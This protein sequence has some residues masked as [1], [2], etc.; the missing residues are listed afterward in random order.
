MDTLID[1]DTIEHLD[2]DEGITCDYVTE[3]LCEEAAVWSILVRCC[4]TKFFFCQT[5]FD[6]ILE[7]IPTVEAFYCNCCRAIV[8]P[9]SR[10]ILSANKI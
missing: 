1:K 10:M 8:K 2:F 4:G 7:A 9:P 3:P 6:E 5:H